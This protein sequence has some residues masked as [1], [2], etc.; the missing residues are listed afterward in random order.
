MN[1]K[2]RRWW[3]L[4]PLVLLPLLML[5]W[6]ELQARLGRHLLSD[7]PELVVEALPPG[8]DP[9]APR[10]VYEGP[11]ASRVQLDLSVFDFP[12]SPGQTGPVDTSLGPL[13]YPFACNTEEVGLGQPL[14]DNQQG[15]GTPVYAELGG[16]KDKT[17]LLGHSKDCLLPTRVEY[18]YKVEGRDDYY[19]WPESGEPA[20]LAWLDWQGS[21]IPFVLRVERGTINRFMYVIAML[22]DPMAPVTDTRSPYWNNKLIYHFKGGVGIGKR[23]GKMSLGRIASRLTKQLAEGYALAG[24]GGNVTSNHYNMWLAANTAEMV[25]AQFVARYGKPDY[26]VG[27]GGSGGA[28]QQYL[29]AQNKPGLLDAI[30]P[31]YSYPDMITQSIWALDCEL[32]EYYFDVTARDNRRWQVQ[33]NRGQVMGVAASS[34]VEHEFKKYYRWAR[35]AGLGLSLPAL[36]PG[37]TE[38]SK[39]WRGLAPLTNNP[40]YFHRIHHYAPAVA[41]ADRFS[42]WHDLAAFYG[43]GED[44]FAHRTHDNVG[45]QYG[46][47]ALKLGQIS[48]AEFLHLNANIGSWKA[49]KDMAQEKLWVLTGDD[50]LADVSIWSDHNMQKTPGSPVPLRVFERNQVDLIKTAP[51]SRGH[52][53]AMA[54]AY[55]SGHVFLGNIDIPVIDLRHYLDNQLD[56]HH[57][58]ATLSSWLRIRQ[59]RGQTDNMIIWQSGKPYDPSDRAFVLLDEWLTKGRRPTAAKD[60]CWTDKGELIA[61]GSEVWNGPWRGDADMGTCLSHYPAYRSPRNAAGSPLTGDLFKCARVPVAEAVARGFYH[62]QEVESYGA[63]LEAVFPEGV[64]DYRQGDVAR[65]ADAELGLTPV[66]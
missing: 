58:Y 59:A 20:D 6:S 33:E 55:Y 39:S 43:V 54:A 62:P 15:I 21:T 17:R 29:I 22:A 30:I 5:G 4:L 65:P 57:S 2:S 23:Q 28:V 16:V 32:L 36:P 66:I 19:L 31:Q 18:F 8:Y 61:E 45:V 24:S 38:C 3:W 50:S 52:D 7:P 60:A 63:M 41:R 26:T 56:M 11:H 9:A 12:V 49:S 14:V 1:K 34:D 48:M 51:R 35:V 53:G 64:C 47:E 40:R 44:G 46:L 37:A 42:H 25:K 27:I 10:P 13:Q